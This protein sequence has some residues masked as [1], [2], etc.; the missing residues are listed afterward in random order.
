MAGVH[1]T[2]TLT[3]TPDS[4]ADLTLELSGINADLRDLTAT[5]LSFSINFAQ[6]SDVLARP[7]GEI[8]LYR[9]EL[10]DGSATEISRVSYS[11]TRYWRGAIN[12]SLNIAGRTTAAWAAGVPVTLANVSLDGTYSDG[13]RYLETGVLDN[14]KPGD[15]VTYDAVATVIESVAIRASGTFSNQVLVEVAV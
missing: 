11:E 9:T 13:R 6:L 3:G 2:A 7:N 10:P 15:T 14:V 12:S 5:F 8:V 4:L 1:W